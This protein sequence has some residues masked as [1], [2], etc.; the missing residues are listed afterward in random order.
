MPQVY[1]RLSYASPTYQKKVIFK[2]FIDSILMAEETLYSRC[3]EIAPA[4]LS[5]CSHQPTL[6]KRWIVEMESFWQAILTN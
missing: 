3:Q 6:L 1:I 4:H 2:F 5:L